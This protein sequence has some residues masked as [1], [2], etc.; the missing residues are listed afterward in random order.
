MFRGAVRMQSLAPGDRV[1]TL[2]GSLRGAIVKILDD[3]RVKWRT[4]S[5]TELIALPEALTLDD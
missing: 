1:R 2:K 4:E 3:G 5:G